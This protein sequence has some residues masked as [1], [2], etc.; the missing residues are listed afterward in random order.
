MFFPESNLT[1]WLYATA[2]DMRNYAEYLVM[3]STGEAAQATGWFLEKVQ[4]III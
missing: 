4:H 3:R 2:T 1:I